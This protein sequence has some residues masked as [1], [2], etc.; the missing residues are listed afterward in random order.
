MLFLSIN[1]I[2]KSIT[3]LL[4]DLFTFLIKDW[5]C[6][7]VLNSNKH[8]NLKYYWTIN[9]VNKSWLRN[10]RWTTTNCEGLH[11]SQFLYT[12]KVSH[13]S[14]VKLDLRKIWRVLFSPTVATSWV[15]ANKIEY[16][17]FFPFG[18]CLHTFRNFRTPPIN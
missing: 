14:S 7:D 12:N 15:A 4:L 13:R 10:L 16:R 11:T 2:I 9:Q 3:Q 6:I 1:P 18:R 5:P 17:A 8:I